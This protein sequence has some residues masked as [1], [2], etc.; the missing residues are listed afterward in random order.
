MCVHTGPLPA[1]PGTSRQA[2][3]RVRDPCLAEKK[4]LRFLCGANADRTGGRK[5]TG[6][7]GWLAY[8][9]YG[10]QVPPIPDPL[11]TSAEHRRKVEERLE[12]LAHSGVVR[13][14]PAIGQASEPQVDREVCVERPRVVPQVL[15]GGARAGSARVSDRGHP[16]GLRAGG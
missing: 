3:L 9:V 10:L 6:R 8:C 11:D 15:K 12:D 13:G 2:L 14:V 16:K 1:P 5:S 7:W 4:L